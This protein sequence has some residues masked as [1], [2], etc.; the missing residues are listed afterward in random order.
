MTPILSLVLYPILMNL[1]LERSR[2][3]LAD[4]VVLDIVVTSRSSRYR[5]GNEPPRPCGK[6]P[7]I[8]VFW[9]VCVVGFGCVGLH[10]PETLPT[11]DIVR[12][13]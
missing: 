7:M 6:I 11:L 5:P 10:H 12:V 1:S 13:W 3:D 9:A 8:S 4:G 2:Q